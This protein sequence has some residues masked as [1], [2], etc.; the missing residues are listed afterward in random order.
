[1]II[2]YLPSSDG[3]NLDVAH[4]PGFFNLEEITL[5]QLEQNLLV[6]DDR[7]K[8]ALEEGTRYRDYAGNQ[9]PSYLGYRVV[10]IITVY[11]PTPRGPVIS[12][13]ING[14]PVFHPDH[15]SIFDR[16]D[17]EHYINDLGI[18]EIWIW[19]Y[20]SDSGYPSY[21]P[22]I[23][24]PC[25]FRNFWE[26]N[27]AS[28]TTLDISNS[29]Q[30]TSDLPVFDQTY[31]VY[32]QNIRRSQAEAIHNHGHQIER[33]IPYINN[34]QDGNTLLFWRDFVGQDASQNFITGRCGWT[35]MP[36]N[37]TTHYDYENITLVS[38]D[39]QDWKPNG[40]TPSLVNVNTWGDLAYIWPGVSMFPQRK[41]SQWYIFWMQS[42][43]G[44]ANVIPHGSNYMTNWWNIIA[45]W[46]LAVNSGFGLYNSTPAPNETQT[47]VVN[48]GNAG[49]GTLRSTIACA[50]SGSTITFSPDM[51]TDTLTILSPIPINKTINVNGAG[52]PGLLLNASSSTFAFDIQNN[53]IVDLFS[54]QVTCGMNTLHSGIRNFGLTGLHDINFK[55]TLNTPILSNHNTLKIY[56]STNLLKF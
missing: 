21:N 45:D 35:H 24:L 9:T 7:V 33:M 14:F 47:V 11:E 31:I 40:G 30:D 13:D 10:S 34:L 53:G 8:F 23:H 52:I 39:I 41:E 50:Q 17:I 48:P 29:N 36:P 55:T 4:A 56:G 28:P 27:M 18:K 54:L 12:Y 46:D 43:P 26:S 49:Y 38:S 6:L 25:N 1:M 51:T 5:S 15:H 22:D 32:G 2:R 42:L 19:E 3:T 37:T 20:A 16:F 44:H